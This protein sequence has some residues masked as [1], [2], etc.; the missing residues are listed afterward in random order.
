MNKNWQANI[1]PSSDEKFTHKFCFSIKMN[2]F[3]VGVRKMVECGV[4]N[5]NLIHMGH[6]STRQMFIILYSNR[7]ATATATG[8]TKSKSSHIKVKFRE[9]IIF[10][11]AFTPRKT[12]ICFQIGSRANKSPHWAPV[13]QINYIDFVFLLLLLLGCLFCK[14]KKQQQQEKLL[15]KFQRKSFEM[16]TIFASW[17]YQTAWLIKRAVKEFS[18]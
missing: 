14:K 4:T 1:L 2:G 3:G 5:D 15:E 18:K 10:E 9:S 7:R 16:L 12:K 6:R 11:M 13:S 8:T 17:K